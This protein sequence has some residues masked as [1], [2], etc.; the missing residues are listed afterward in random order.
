M[1][2]KVVMGRRHAFA[3]PLIECE[4]SERSSTGGM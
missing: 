1:K 4:R 3:D 2:Q